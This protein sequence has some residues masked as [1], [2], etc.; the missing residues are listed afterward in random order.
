MLP[1]LV[2]AADGPLSR[3]DFDRQVRDALLHLNDWVYLQSHPLAGYLPLPA[4]PNRRNRGQ[5]LYEVIRAVIGDF[6]TDPRRGRR[7]SARNNCSACGTSTPRPYPRC[8]Q[9]SA[10]ARARTTAFIGVR[11]TP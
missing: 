10:S 8:R 7:G 3:D 6:R 4:A 2:N 5:E 1:I 9:R 11:W